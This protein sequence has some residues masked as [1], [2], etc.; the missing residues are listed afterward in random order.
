VIDGGSEVRSFLV[1]QSMDQQLVLL[2]WSKGRDGWK[3]KERPAGRARHAMR[4]E[5]ENAGR[6]SSSFISSIR[7]EPNN[8][9][10]V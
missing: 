9:G 3:E 1:D 7:S 4:M 6:G 5:T 2:H 10:K 8:R